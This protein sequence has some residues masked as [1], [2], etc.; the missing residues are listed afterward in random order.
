MNRIPI[1]IERAPYEVLVGAG[2]LDQ[3]HEFLP[4]RGGRYM[5]VTNVTVRP[6]YEERVVASLRRTGA[7]VSSLS[8]PDGEAYK[9]WHTL[10]AI[11]DALLAQHCDRRT[12]LVALGGGVIGDMTGFAAATYMRG[13]PFIQIPT[14]L[15]AQVDSSVGG[16]TAINHPRGKNMIGAFYQPTHVFA[17][18][19]T[20]KTLPPR[21]V[22]AGMAEVVKHGLIRDA[23]FFQWCERHADRLL[24]GDVEALTHAVTRSVQIKA[25]VV[26]ADPTEQGVRAHLN[27]GHTFGHALEAALGYGNWLHG[28]AVGC[29]LVLA[30]DLSMRLGFLYPEAVDRVRR[31]VR[32]LNLPVSIPGLSAE[33]LLEHMRVDKKVEAGKLRFVVLRDIGVAEVQAVS[34]S[35]ARDTLVAGGASAR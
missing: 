4:Q 25:A 17:D 31:C 32:A 5:V 29:G 13:V 8:L 30:A 19:E 14:T 16:K 15:L 24:A 33:E 6:L 21:E 1:E 20:L 34:P 28:E 9:T 7:E 11:Y 22:S 26:A 10:N 27:L 12:V 35:L 3:L 18:V 23:D 2:L